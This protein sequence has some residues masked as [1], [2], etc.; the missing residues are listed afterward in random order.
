M[1]KK[2][3]KKNDIKDM[4]KDEGYGKILFEKNKIGHKMKRI[5]SK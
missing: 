1:I 5:Q 4:I 3:K 2:K